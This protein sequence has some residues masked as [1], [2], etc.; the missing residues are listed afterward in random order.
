M[1]TFLG[2]DLDEPL[3]GELSGDTFDLASDSL[4]EEFSSFD[5]CFCLFLRSYLGL[6]SS[7]V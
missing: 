7:I 3:P 5:I 2:S 1:L 6:D 4:L